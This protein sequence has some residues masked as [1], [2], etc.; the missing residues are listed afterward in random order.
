M[1][2]YFDKNCGLSGSGY[3]AEERRGSAE[4]DFSFAIKNVVPKMYN[5]SGLMVPNKSE[6]VESKSKKKEALQEI[7]QSS[8]TKNTDIVAHEKS[9]K[10][11]KCSVSKDNENHAH[12]KQ[13][14]LDLEAKLTMITEII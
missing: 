13:K 5:G 9:K 14:I 1:K 11:S 12:Y 10:R 8:S 4:T 7:R 3:N 6:V 2:R